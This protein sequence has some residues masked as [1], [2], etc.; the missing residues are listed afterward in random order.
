MANH[1]DFVDYDDCSSIINRL[2]QDI[3]YLEYERDYYKQDHETLN[4]ISQ[5]LGN[6]EIIVDQ[7]LDK[8]IINHFKDIK[9]KGNGKDS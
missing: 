4:K 7:P 5:E 9:E 2:R 1:P 8:F 3:S 6:L